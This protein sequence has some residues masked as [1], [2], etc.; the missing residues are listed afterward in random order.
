M[1]LELDDLEKQPYE[2]ANFWQRLQALII[3]TIIFLPITSVNGY[4]LMEWK[5]FEIIIIVALIWCIYKPFMEWKW[6]ATLGKMIVGLK[7]VNKNFEGIDFNQAMLRFSIYFAW[8]VASVLEYF[9]LFNTPGFAETNTYEGIITL[10]QHNP[11][12]AAS[13]VSFMFI[14]SASRIFF[15]AHKQAYHDLPGDTYCISTKKKLY[16]PT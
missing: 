2:Y 15:D 7:V 5:R 8:T 1:R 6:G 14:F 9:N 10:Q 11:S 13:I 4:N 12:V 3:D 16:V